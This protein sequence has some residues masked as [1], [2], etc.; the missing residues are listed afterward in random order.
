MVG[1]GHI[2]YFVPKVK[3]QDYNFVIDDRNF[4]DQL[5]ENDIRKTIKVNTGQ[6]NDY[7]TG[8]LLDYPYFIED[9]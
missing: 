2:G 5:V 6:A 3:I 1:T 4:F 8:C 9:Q 7:K